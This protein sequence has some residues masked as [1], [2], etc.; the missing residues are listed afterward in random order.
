MLLEEDPEVRLD[1]SNRA[2]LL[3]TLAPKVG[4]THL[5]LPDLSEE[6]SYKGCSTNT[7][8]IK[9]DGLGEVVET[10]DKPEHAR[11]TKLWHKRARSDS[12]LPNKKKI[13]Y[14]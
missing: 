6:G 10:P 4:T 11:W 9:D 14:Y 2:T 7:Q 12:S 1:P 13:S 8:D 5:N 3:N